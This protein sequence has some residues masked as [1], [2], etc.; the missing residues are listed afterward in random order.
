MTTTATRTKATDPRALKEHVRRSLP[1]LTLEQIQIASPCQA[2]WA[3]MQG[4]ERTRHCG[5]CKKDVHDLSKMTRREAEALVSSVGVDGH[6]PCIRMWVRAD[7][8]VITQDCPKGLERARR[9]LKKVGAAFGA[10]F[11][12]LV[13]LTGCTREEPMM[14]A[15]SVHPQTGSTTPA[16]TPSNGVT[17]AGTTTPTTTGSTGST[18]RSTSTPPST[19]PVETDTPPAGAREVRGEPGVPVDSARTP[20]TP[21]ADEAGEPRCIMGA[22]P[23]PPPPTQAPGV[24]NGR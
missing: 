21:P 3:S 7:G 14:G 22:P 15:P 5:E 4:D 11:G 24:T 1:T 13:G 6:R 18:P 10:L 12:V 8:T 17:P 2:S 23:P 9:W 16:A 19:R 20:V